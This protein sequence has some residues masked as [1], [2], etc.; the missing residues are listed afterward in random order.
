MIDALV[1]GKLVGAVVERTASS[2]KTFVTGKVHAAGSDGEDKFLNV[3][4]FDDNV[5]SMLLTLGDG[6]SVAVSGTM[7]VGTYEARDGTTRN[8]INVVASDVLSAYGVKR[9]REQY[10]AIRRWARSKMTMWISERRDEWYS[11]VRPSQFSTCVCGLAADNSHMANV[12]DRYRIML[13]E[14]SQRVRLAY[15][16]TADGHYVRIVTGAGIP[17]ATLSRS[18]AIEAGIT[19]RR[20]SPKPK[21]AREPRPIDSRGERRTDHQE[22]P[23]PAVQPIEWEHPGTALATLKPLLETGGGAVENVIVRLGLN[24]HYPLRKRRYRLARFALVGNVPFW[25]DA[26]T[27][28]PLYQVSGWVLAE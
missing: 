1:A 28:R 8:S 13:A 23:M 15:L 2:G 27:H 10:A 7:N 24:R 26:M 17:V 4:A 22:V 21:W 20:L 3:V 9:K 25:L 16:E 5:K 11:A 18:V 19:S 12:A 6:D 14:L